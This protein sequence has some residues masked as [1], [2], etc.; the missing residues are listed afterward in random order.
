MFH[1]QAAKL[2][3][4]NAAVVLSTGKAI[5]VLGAVAAAGPRVYAKDEEARLDAALR[6]IHLISCVRVSPMIRVFALAKA[7]FGWVSRFSG[8]VHGVL[9]VVRV[10]VPLS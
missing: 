3:Q 9:R 1:C 7:A 4:L 5:R 6:N 10:L 2:A 8:L